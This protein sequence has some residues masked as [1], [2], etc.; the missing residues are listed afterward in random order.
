MCSPPAV[1]LI[2][3]TPLAREEICYPQLQIGPR[4]RCISVSRKG[5]DGTILAVATKEI[6]VVGAGV[7]GLTTAF[8]LAQAD[9]R[10][11]LIDP[12]PGRGA[13]F[14]AAGLIAPVTE[15]VY[16]EESLV[17]L[18][19]E[20]ARRWPE[21]ADDI[22]SHSAF[23]CG[24]D[25]SGTLFVAHDRNDQERVRA[26]VP[27]YQRLGLETH[28]R[29]R[30]TLKQLEP[31]LA[32]SI[33][34]GL[35][36]PGDIQVD[37]RRLISSLTDAL[38]SYG[39]TI[40]R[41]TV[42]EV[43]VANGRVTGV[44]TEHRRIRSSHVVLCVG[45]NIG[46]ISG[47]PDRDHLSLRP[48]KGQILRLLQR[49]PHLRLRR[50]VRA[51]VAGSAIYLVP[52]A[53]GQLV[54]GATVEEQGLAHAPTAGGAYT[55]LRDAIAVVPS[56]AEAEFE[57]IEV[58]FRPAALDNAPIIGPGSNEGLIYA[59]GCYRHG[60]LFSPVV[61]ASVAELIRTGEVPEIVRPFSPDRLP[62]PRV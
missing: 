22:N 30:E 27:L 44:T 58:G 59:L 34:G 25:R 23:D 16:G 2:S 36:V 15:A 38:T 57:S 50:S 3:G 49:D 42:R 18:S 41:E 52:R 48:V 56:V 21:H 29:G 28:W 7:I 39:V 53:S 10:V 61:A 46:A 17:E 20:A 8:A 11:I 19:L 35:E 24:L 31:L 51:L 45:Y 14:V 26:Q 60:V 37:N 12:F 4:Q 33:R 55:L 9:H 13:S 43:V 6:A 47:L 40:L 1:W 62:A 54:V 32:P 5:E